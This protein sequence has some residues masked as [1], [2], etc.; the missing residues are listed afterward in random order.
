ML[1]FKSYFHP[2]HVKQFINYERKK[3]AWFLKLLKRRRQPHRIEVSVRTTA[4]R[5]LLLTDV[6]QTVV[7]AVL[8]VD[9]LSDRSL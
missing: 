2:K 6:G 3:R 9:S 7:L 1:K 4:L 5:K 8:A